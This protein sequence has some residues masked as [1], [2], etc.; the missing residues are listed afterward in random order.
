MAIAIVD[1]DEV[2][3]DQNM[4]FSIA[5]ILSGVV[6]AMSGVDASSRT[7]SD[8]TQQT[9]S[10]GANPSTVFA[11]NH[12]Y[13]AKEISSLFARPTTVTE[14]LRNLKLAWDRKLLVQPEFFDDSNLMRF[15][16]GTAVVWNKPPPGMEADWTIRTG[17]LTVDSKEFPNVV[18]GLRQSHHV[19]KEQRAPALNLV[20]PAYTQDTGSIAMRVES[21]SGFTWGAVK[22][23]F[24]PDAKDT[25]VF[26]IWEGPGPEPRDG[27]WAKA[28]AGKAS[29]RY[30]Y[31]GDDPSKLD[32]VDLSKATFGLY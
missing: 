32:A 20:I 29:M 30:L 25:G 26:G 9:S 17:T 3:E 14:L 15:F 24:G 2:F 6:F 8:A 31:P 13:T 22:Q 18:V 19:A 4:K 16:N 7:N 27:P 10:N 21:V 11:M 28:L 23:I 12:V 5:V 1:N